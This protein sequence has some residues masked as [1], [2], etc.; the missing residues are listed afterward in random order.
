MSLNPNITMKFVL[1][2]PD[3]A[4][5]WRYLSG[6]CGITMQDVQSHPEKPWNLGW[7]SHNPNLTMEFVL[8]NESQSW[9][10]GNLSHNTFK[11]SWKRVLSQEQIELI[12]DIID[13]GYM[14]PDYS[15]VPVFKKGGRLF[16]ENYTFLKC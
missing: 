6:N 16:W 14:P 13:K 5:G 8:A 1:S 10:W 2:H 15:K 9:N 12:K 11:T 7:M 3:E 4:W